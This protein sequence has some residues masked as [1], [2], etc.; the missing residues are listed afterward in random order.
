MSNK[1]LRSGEEAPVTPIHWRSGKIERICRSPA[2]AET[3]AALDTEDD[4]TYL[5]LLWNEMKG[6]TINTYNIDDSVKATGAVLIVDARNLYDK[7]VRATPC[8]KGAE[9]RST[10]ES[11]GLRQNL[12][13]GQTEVRWVDG[14]GMLANVLT[15]VQEKVQGWLFM[16]LGFRWK[17]VHDDL[18]ASQRKRRAAGL[19]LV[20][21]QHKVHTQ[22]Q[23][24]QQQQAQQQQQQQQQQ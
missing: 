13:R 2:A 11:I 10:I 15:K 22:Q 4:L 12:E 21:I 5:R 7:L 3:M 16:Q 18:H 24:Q 1:R 23:Q 9:K 14:G 6:L 17:I 20:D 19:D 8:V